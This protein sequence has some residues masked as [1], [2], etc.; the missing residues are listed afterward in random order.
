MTA[1]FEDIV[2]GENAAIGA[3]RFTADEI[4]AFARDFDPQ[5]FHVDEDAATTSHFG[6]LC[7][8]GW[9]TA[10]I[11]MRLMVDHRSRMADQA[12]ACGEA[13]AAF[14]PSPGFRDLKWRKPVFAEDT[15][16]Y[17][18]ETTGKR[19]SLSRPDWGLFD[20]RILAANQHGETVMSVLCTGF[21]ARRERGAT[22]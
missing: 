5:S 9:H 22:P 6:A 2:I 17:A 7:A 8:S 15:I 1:F 19:A 4:K 3:H 20:F 10:A 14:G 13:V 11:G 12:R 16:S 21:V 18:I